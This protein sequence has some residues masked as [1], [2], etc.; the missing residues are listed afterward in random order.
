[1]VARKKILKKKS[2]SF[3]MYANVLNKPLF[4]GVPTDHYGYHKSNYVDVLIQ[5]YMHY[6][7]SGVVLLFVKV[8]LQG[9]PR[10]SR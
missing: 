9:I 1:M 7:F 10:M 2:I 5:I 6:A 8:E 3:M 4:L